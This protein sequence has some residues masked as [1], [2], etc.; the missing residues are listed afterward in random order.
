MSI[1]AIES[2]LIDNK[3]FFV[4]PSW[5]NLLGYP[6]LGKY[7]NHTV[8]KI[9]KDLV[10]FLG[11]I[12]CS[13][14]TERGTLYYLFGLG[15]YYVT[16]E[17]QS[18]IYITDQRQLTGLALSD[19]VYDHL[20]TSKN[21]SLETDRD[22]IVGEKLFKLPID[23]SFKSENKITFIQGTL[24]R[25]L[26]IPY[27]DVFLEFMKE[28]QKPT[29]FQIEKN[30]HMILSTYWDY[31]NEIL[32]SRNMEERTK[33][34]FLND[35]AGL[36]DISFGVD[37]FL[38]DYLSPSEMKKINDI[39][40]ELKVAYA[41]IDYDPMF[42]Y[43]II[44]NSSSLFKSNAFTFNL[45]DDRTYKKMPKESIFI[46]AEDR[47]NNFV[48]WSSY[49][50]RQTKEQL[51]ATAISEKTRIY[52]PKK[53]KTLDKVE[54]P[55]F[56]RKDE[57]FE[58]RTERHPFVE[59]KPLPFIPHNNVLEILLT[60]KR[61]VE[62]DYEIRTIGKAFEIGRD[63]IKKK[64]LHVNYLWNMSKYVN[65]YRKMKPNTGLSLNEK[66]D[67]LKNIKDWI[68]ITHEKLDNL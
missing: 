26:F 41:S 56:K 52:H 27:K 34:E 18:G 68:K 21:I 33:A 29:S 51:E 53:K 44:E 28:V 1:H 2:K 9:S 61:M 49:H 62:E 66:T 14:P 38:H 37:E 39:I 19:F 50:Q 58:L 60:L 55:D 17:L 67:L 48:E 12:E 36:F 6:T 65:L 63:Q 30:G 4:I 45:E 7:A 46:S 5:G 24:M 20:A 3:I 32:I 42:L 8:S 57:E 15:Y 11:G 25:N 22:V 43:S 54:I 64:V 47:L 23:M 31:F 59:F 13:I 10:I 40:L 16:F 35:T